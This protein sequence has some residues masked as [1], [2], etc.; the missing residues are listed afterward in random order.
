ML[1][2]VGAPAELLEWSHRAAIEEIA[3]ARLCFALAA[4]YGG[5]THTVQPI[6]AMLGAGLGVKGD[7]IDVLIRESL[8]DGCQLEDFNADIAAECAAVCEEPATFDVL[9]RI[10]R[11]ERSHAE[12][13]WAVIGWL[14][15]RTAAARPALERALAKLDGYARPTAVSWQKRSLVALADPDQLRRHGRLPDE[16][17][18]ELWRE[19][20][21]LTK[22][23]ARGLL[24]D[25]T[26][27]VAAAAS[28]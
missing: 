15:D 13:S 18:A 24:A 8:G 22:R 14:L 5:R 7:P 16:R 6:P 23:R 11:E 28:L 4:G 27:D 10:A 21:E 19:R 26:T 1:A 20:L 2:A 9:A 12:F 17:W 25:A 3:H